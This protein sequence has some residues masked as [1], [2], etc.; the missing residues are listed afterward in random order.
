M[1]DFLNQVMETLTFPRIFFMHTIKLKSKQIKRQTHFT[2]DI[3]KPDIISKTKCVSPI[4]D[5]IY[6]LNLIICVFSLLI[7]FFSLH[8]TMESVPSTSQSGTPRLQRRTV[9]NKSTTT[10]PTKPGK[11]FQFNGAVSGP[12]VKQPFPVQDEI[13]D[14]HTSSACMKYKALRFGLANLDENAKLAEMKSFAFFQKKF[15]IKFHP[16]TVITPIFWVF[17]SFSGFLNFLRVQL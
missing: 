5:F 9:P 12:F 11:L 3:S 4:I 10:A 2:P 13:T 17:S 15:A 7:F 16:K 14:V 6:L 8:K 1:F